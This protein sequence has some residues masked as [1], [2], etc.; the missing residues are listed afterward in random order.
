MNNE[1]KILSM[2][3]ELKESVDK[4]FD[5]VDKRLDTV[6]GR[7]DELDTRSLRSAVILETE[8][9]KKIQ[10]LYEGQ[11]LLRQKMDELAP[12][13]RVEVLEDRVITLETLVKSMSKRLAALEKAQ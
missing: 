11:G 8:V 1:E 7:L 5:A 2:L 9:A 3:V 10:L 13:E 6:E 12:R 4:R